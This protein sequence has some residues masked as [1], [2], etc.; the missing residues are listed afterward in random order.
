[1]SCLANEMAD[2]DQKCIPL[3]GDA[4]V[5][6]PKACELAS[7]LVKLGHHFRSNIRQVLS[8]SSTK[9]YTI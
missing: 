1:M 7:Q 4:Q 9:V 8:H 2:V 6:F 3:C 5:P